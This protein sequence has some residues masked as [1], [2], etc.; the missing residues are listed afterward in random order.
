MLPRRFDAGLVYLA[1][2]SIGLALALLAISITGRK[3]ISR[4]RWAVDTH[5]N[6]RRGLGALF[7]VIGVVVLFG[8]QVKVETWVADHLPFDETKV[9]R[10]LLA[11]Q[12]KN[13]IVHNLAQRVQN[14]TS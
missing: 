3:Y 11:G 13:N 9:E 10:I 5:S 8:Y 2:Y 1:T 14:N 4:F 12:H 6:F 7:I